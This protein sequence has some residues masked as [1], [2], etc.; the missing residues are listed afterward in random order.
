MM[1]NSG[2]GAMGG[3][4]NFTN[5]AG[6]GSVF[7]SYMTGGGKKKGSKNKDRKNKDRKNKDRKNKGSTKKTPLRKKIPIKTKSMSKMRIRNIKKLTKRQTK[8]ERK[9]K[10]EKHFKR[11]KIRNN[12]INSLPSTNGLPKQVT[13]SLS[14][15]M[16][17]FISKIPR[18]SSSASSI[19]SMSEIDEVYPVYKEKPST[20]SFEDAR[21]GL[22]DILKKKH[23]Y[24]VNSKSVIKFSDYKSKMKPK[25]K[26][27]L[28]YKSKNKGRTR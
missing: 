22:G 23:V 1:I 9:T 2:Y 5:I 13:S 10:L 3:F 19:P 18:Y 16:L 6:L 15:D 12:I 24:P 28:K 7:E 4:D 11:R 27:A 14:P 20:K 26:A 17:Q 8:L 21:M 25:E